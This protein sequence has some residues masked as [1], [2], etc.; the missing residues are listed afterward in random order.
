MGG[1]NTVEQN[2]VATSG[3]V[4]FLS[5]IV[6]TANSLKKKGVKGFSALLHPDMREA[7][8]SGRNNQANILGGG[9]VSSP[10]QE[11]IS[12]E[13]QQRRKRNTAGGFFGTLGG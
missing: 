1:K 2:R 8:K 10:Q 6:N 3:L 9:Q 13:E 7:I 12:P 5:P 4:G 11:G